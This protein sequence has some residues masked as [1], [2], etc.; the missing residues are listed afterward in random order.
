MASTKL[1]FDLF[2]RVDGV[3]IDAD[4]WERESRVRRLS[5]ERFVAGEVVILW[6]HAPHVAGVVTA[7]GER[8]TV[9]VLR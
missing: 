6:P 8:V 9:R 3:A 5:P 2:D 1:K 7:S 4:L